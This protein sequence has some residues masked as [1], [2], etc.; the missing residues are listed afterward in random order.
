MNR[1]VP[2]QGDDAFAP[3]T[4]PTLQL[5]DG[6]FVVESNNCAEALESRYPEPSLH[7]DA[8]LHRTIMTKVDQASSNIFPL[9]LVILVQ[10]WL[11]KRSA[12]YF[13]ED[14]AK[15]FGISIEDLSKYK[16]E[17]QWEAGEVPG[18]NFD[19]LKDELTKHKRDEGPYV[20]GSQVSYGDFVLASLFESCERVD[21]QIYDRLMGFD[22]S[23]KQL[24]E[25]CR[26]WFQRDD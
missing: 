7:L 4:S 9:A 2:P 21:K 3:Y 6:K 16:G 22:P 17:E 20:L 12:E 18:G 15:R 19:Q 26:P 11:P 23:F 8:R 25:A 14:R 10:K 5:P 1:G 13:A 24:H